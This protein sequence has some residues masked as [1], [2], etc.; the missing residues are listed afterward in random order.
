MYIQRILNL[1]DLLKKKSHFLFGPRQTGKSSLIAEELQHSYPIINLLKTD[2]Y[3]RLEASPW[4]LE[5]MIPSN[6]EC[7][8]I[9][10]VQRIPILLNEVHRLIEEKKIKF[11]LTGSSARK[12]RRQNA[13]MLGGRAWKAEL[14]PLVSNEIEEFDLN[15]YLLYGG[16]PPVYLGSE[17]DQELAAYVDT[18]LKDEIQAEAI[19]RN[20]P[21]FV[22]FLHGAALSS[23]NILNYTKLASDLQVAPNTIKE[24]YSILSDTLIGF[25]VLPFNMTKKRKSL[26]SSKFY[27]FDLGVKN[28][29]CSIKGIPPKTD[30]YGQAFEHF[31]C[32]EIRAY[33]SYRKKHMEMTFWMTTNHQEVDLIIGTELAIEVKSTD[34]ITK[35]HLKGIQLLKEENICK[36]YCVVSLD[37]TIS[38]LEGIKIYHWQDFLKILWSDQI[39]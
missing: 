19:V 32:L 38:Q 28:F 4:E 26:S 21:A 14:F 5:N 1:N 11:L 6:A 25:H 12:L 17:P 35:K 39:V 22:R 13:N 8:V 15:K 2:I 33:L 18:Y 20:L 24:F 27:F 23:G 16:L 3:L 7:V 37:K 30:L 10:E 29:L 34:K 31:I 9:D 36:N